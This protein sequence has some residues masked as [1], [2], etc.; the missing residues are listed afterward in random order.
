[1]VTCVCVTEIVPPDEWPAKGEV[2]FESVS[3]SYDATLEPVVTDFNL[4]V[5]GGETVPRQ[6]FHVLRV[7]SNNLIGIDKLCTY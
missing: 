3:L 4:H 2:T 1:M 7:F 5:H 6:C